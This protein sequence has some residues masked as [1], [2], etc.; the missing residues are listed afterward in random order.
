MKIDTREFI[1]LVLLREKYLSEE[2]Y[3]DFLKFEK[4]KYH[5]YCHYGSL[6]CN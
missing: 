4:E 1:E 5:K 2:E 6:I 3:F